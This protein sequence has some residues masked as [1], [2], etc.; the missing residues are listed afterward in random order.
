MSW[1]TRLVNVFRAGKVSDDIDRELA[2]HVAERADELI[3]AGSPPEAA[4]LEARRRLGNHAVQ[5]EN[6]RDHDVLVW[7]E[8]FVADVRGGV[9][10]LV[11]QPI[12]AITTILTLA[13]GIGANTVVFTLL[14]GLLLRSLPVRAP[15]ELVRINLTLD[16]D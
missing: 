12:F 10:A 11:K 7:V 8:S 6:V 2:F 5:R 14:H 15:Q 3:A 13:I 1:L 4:R 16:A 9:R